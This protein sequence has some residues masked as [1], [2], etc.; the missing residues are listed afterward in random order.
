MYSL[1]LWAFTIKQI[2]KLP[3]CCSSKKTVLHSKAPDAEL[4]GRCPN[5]SVISKHL[6]S[7]T[8]LEIGQRLSTFVSIHQLLG[9]VGLSA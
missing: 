3:D 1:M 6:L 4:Q 9:F 7:V 5:A 8:W 2:C